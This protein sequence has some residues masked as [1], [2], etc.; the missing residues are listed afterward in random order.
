MNKWQVDTKRFEKILQ[1]LLKRS[2]DW[3][4]LFHTLGENFRQSR[5]TIF[6]LTGPGGYKDLSPRYKKLKES[7]FGDAYPILRAT[8]VM[9]RSIVE[10]GDSNNVSIVERRSFTFG[11]KDPILKYHN[12]DK[13]AKGGKRKMPQ[14]K[15]IFWGPEAPKTMPLE[16]QNFY[17][18]AKQQM[19]RYLMRERAQ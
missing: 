10:E 11:S 1:R 3:R 17:D 12:S 18:R 2:D 15:V 7:I 4:P 9:E 8:G 16:S 14:R 19:L 13:P 6:A 5:K